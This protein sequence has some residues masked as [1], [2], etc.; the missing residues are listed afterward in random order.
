MSP[1]YIREGP[2]HRC[3]PRSPVADAVKRVSGDIVGDAGA[4]DAAHPRRV[5]L[6]YLDDSLPARV[7]VVAQ[8]EPAQ[9]RHRPG[10]RGPA[11]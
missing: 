5:A 8:R 9:R 7:V 11:S 2:T 4:F 1:R 6:R 3:A 10:D